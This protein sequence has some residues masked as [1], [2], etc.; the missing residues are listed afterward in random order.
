M[1][2]LVHHPEGQGDGQ[3]GPGLKIGSRKSSMKVE[4]VRPLEKM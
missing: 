3:G 2:R 1:V 4:N